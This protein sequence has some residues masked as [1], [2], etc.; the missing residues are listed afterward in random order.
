MKTLKI[1]GIAI[2]LSLLISAPSYSQ[3]LLKKLK[4]KTEQKLFKKGDQALDDALFGDDDNKQ[5]NTG[6]STNNSGNNS[7]TSNT[8]G[9]GLVKEPPDVLKNIN[10]A[11]QA[12]DVKNYGTAKYSVRQAML[13]IE[14][15]IGNDILE[16]LPNSIDG[17]DKVEAKDQVTSMSYGFVGLTMERV[18]QGGDKELSINIGNNSALLSAANMMLSTGAYST[19]SDDQNYKQTTF[20]GYRSVLQFDNSTG[21]TLSVPFGQSSIMVVNGINY[22]SESEIMAAADNIDIE[23]IKQKLGEQ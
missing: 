18:Y 17:L 8:K 20:K 12:F 7:S 16:S 22:N 3:S 1:S 23:S 21:Y 13:G 6:N 11:G 19:S 5:G 4:K 15:E 9:E 2:I 10:D 14:M